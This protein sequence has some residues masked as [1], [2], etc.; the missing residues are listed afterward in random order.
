MKTGQKGTCTLSLEDG[1]LRKLSHTNP[2]TPH[3]PAPFHM[4][5][6]RNSSLPSGWPCAQPEIRAQLVWKE[7]VTG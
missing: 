2:P 7:D 6:A 1:L 3:W 4:A 5:K